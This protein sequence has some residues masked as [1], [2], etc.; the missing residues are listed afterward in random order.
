MRCRYTAGLAQTARAAQA[1]LNLKRNVFAPVLLSS[2]HPC[3]QLAC[4]E[5]ARE[6][7]TAVSGVV[8][9]YVPPCVS[10]ERLGRGAG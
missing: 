4:S 10:A 3:S 7:R 1:G 2:E 5:C 8:G 9:E 6:E